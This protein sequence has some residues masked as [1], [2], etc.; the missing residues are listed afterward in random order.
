ME[1]PFMYAPFTVQGF[2][3]SGQVHLICPN[4]QF[5]IFENVRNFLICCE[6]SLAS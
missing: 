2:W 3:A 4:G 1:L 5:E 6:P